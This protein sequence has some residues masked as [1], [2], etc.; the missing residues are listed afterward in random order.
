[1]QNLEQ[2]LKE[3]LTTLQDNLKKAN[4]DAY[5]ITNQEDVWY[6]TNI[7]YKP[8]QRPFLFV[9][10]P[11]KKP[12]FIVPKLEVDHFTVSYFDYEMDNYFDV[13]SKNGENWY[14]VL[15][16]YLA[17]LARVGIESNGELLVT[18]FTPNIN[19][20][21]RF[22][23]QNQR[24]LK[25]EYELD[26]LQYVSDVCSKVVQQTLKI[27]RKGTKV[28]DTYSIAMKVGA[29]ELA[30][31]F[32]LENRTINAVWPAKF[33]FMPHSIP[34][35]NATLGA[36]PNIDIAL[37]N[38]QGYAAE[39]ERTFFVEEPTDEE[40]KHFEQ[41]MM[42]RKIFLENLKPGKK[43]SDIEKVVDSYFEQEGVLN[44]IL[45]RPGHG[46]G[47]NNHEWPTLSLGNDDILQENM[48]ISVEPAI[49]FENHGGYRHS[50]TAVIT[51]DGYRLLTK[52]PT[53]LED[54]ILK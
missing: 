36:G 5:V 23:I 6:F 20:E 9:V 42:A 7:N 1:M 31:N 54:L 30:K 41:M 45:H 37:F 51:K 43:A 24:M 33:S 16:K 52:A 40:R 39:C 25:S 13:T 10:Y 17:P 38:L 18:R 29:E 14:D 46:I 8:E 34:D 19:W 48:V 32:S 49:Y 53:D 35:V 12:L 47:L 26:K 27:S 3:R 21:T 50:D 11:D 28:M 22:L 2:E 15:T 4:L 44:R